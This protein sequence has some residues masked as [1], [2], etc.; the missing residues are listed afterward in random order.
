MADSL[1]V[2]CVDDEANILSSL[3]RLL[4][5]HGYGVLTA[6]SGAEGLAIWSRDGSISFSPTCACPRWMERAFSSR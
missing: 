5:P 4:R 1:T 2:L 6:G 3:R